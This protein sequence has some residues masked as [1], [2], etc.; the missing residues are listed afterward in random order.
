MVDD[1]CSHSLDGA[2]L[3]RFRV[4]QNSHGEWIVQH[5]G[6]R[7]GGIFVDRSEALKYALF[8]NGNHHNAVMIVPGIM[9]LKIRAKDHNHLVLNRNH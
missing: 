8:E 7:Y 6:G 4:G 2:D 3:P 1:K 9:E 5:E